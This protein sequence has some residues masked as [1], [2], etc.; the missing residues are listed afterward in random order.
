M[1]T[2]APIPHSKFWLFFIISLIIIGIEH[3]TTWLIPVRRA[4]DTFVLPVHYAAALPIKTVKTLS[5]LFH[6]IQ[7]VAQENDELKQEKIFLQASVQRMSS[8]EAENQYLR[9]LLKVPYKRSDN[10]ILADVIEIEAS[11]YKKEIL[12]NKGARDSL[13]EGQV[14]IDAT[15]ILG[16]VIRVLPTSA[17]V[18]LLT[19]ISHAIPVKNLRNGERAIAIGMGNDLYLELA[20]VPDTADFRTGDLLVSSGLGGRFPEGYAVGV[21]DEMQYASGED[22]VKVRVKLKAQV[23]RI[24]HVLVIRPL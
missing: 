6:S 8:L 14:V 7:L 16:Q 17:R 15:G 13:H 20:H 22:F 12:I 5:Q 4:L 11:P 24:D 18:L 19:D 10:I 9:Q 23:N 21:I 2:E 1:F 3:E